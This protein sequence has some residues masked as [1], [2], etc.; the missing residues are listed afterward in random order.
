MEAGEGRVRV[1][2]EALEGLLETIAG[3]STEGRVEIQVL[4]LMPQVLGNAGN[5]SLGALRCHDPQRPLPSPGGQGLTRIH[6]E[7][8]AGGPQK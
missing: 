2:G 7:Q 3:R 8:E 6:V 5:P 4:A 1:F